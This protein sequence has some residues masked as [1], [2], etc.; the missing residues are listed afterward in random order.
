[1]SVLCVTSASEQ[2][3]LAAFK[4]RKELSV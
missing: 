1:M 2:V 4:F 3:I